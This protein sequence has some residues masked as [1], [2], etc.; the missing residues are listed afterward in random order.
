MYENVKRG[1]LKDMDKTTLLNMRNGGM[2]N[3]AIAKSLGCSNSTV[4]NLIGPMPPDMVKRIRQESMANARAMKKSNPGKGGIRW[5]A[6]CAVL[7]RRVKNTR[8]NRYPVLCL[9]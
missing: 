1:L 6:R 2:S 8:K 4:T 3:V 9:L 5:N 7:C